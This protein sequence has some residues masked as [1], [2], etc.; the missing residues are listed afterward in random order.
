MERHHFLHS[1]L[2]NLLSAIHI[3]TRFSF[4]QYVVE[5]YI[6][7][8][9]FRDKYGDFRAYRF[10]EPI[11]IVIDRKFKTPY[12]YEYDWKDISISREGNYDFLR[13]FYETT[14]HFSRIKKGW[15]EIIREIAW[16]MENK[17]WDY[18]M[19]YYEQRKIKVNLTN[20]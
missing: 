12:I 17:K 3:V 20:S 16:H 9:E 15:M 10:K 5:R 1:I 11:N 4:Y 2:L 19:N 6:K 7:T 13:Q 8:K 18:P 14:E